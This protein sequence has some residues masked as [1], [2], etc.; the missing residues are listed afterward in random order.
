MASARS[1]GTWRDMIMDQVRA[2]AHE[3]R[4]NTVDT[5]SRYRLTRIGIAIPAHSYLLQAAR[6]RGISVSGYAR[7]AILAHVALDLGLKATDLFE[8]DSFVQPFAGGTPN[9]GERDLDGKLYGR[10]E[11]RADVP[12]DQQ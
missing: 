8:L 10:W 4:K 6:K 3:T 5:G 7:R 9:S 11:V 2:K 1:G 12:G